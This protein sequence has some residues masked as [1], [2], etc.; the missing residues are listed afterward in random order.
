MRK[1]STLQLPVVF[2]DSKPT[3][4]TSHAQDT[5][6]HQLRI[7]DVTY[8]HYHR[9]IELGLCVSGNGICQVE[10]M[11]FPF[12]EGDVQIIFPYQRHLS[13]T[14][15]NSPSMWRWVNID[16]TEV[17]FQAGFT[18]QEHIQ[19]WLCKEMALC[20]II[21]RTRYGEICAT[22]KKVFEILC[23]KPDTFLHPQQL[24]ATQLMDLILQLCEASRMLPK[25]TLHTGNFAAELI[26][27]LNRINEDI[28]AG[29]MPKVT[30]LPALCGMSPANFRRVFKKTLGLSPKIY[31]TQCCIHKAKK[32]LTYTNL[33]VSQIAS[34][35]GYENISG[36]NRCFQEQTGTTPTN[37]RHMMQL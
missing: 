4:L 12:S 29:D 7:Y 13:K 1:Q 35:I 22:V 10:D 20:G 17:F 27:A 18:T 36:F 15:D 21:D 28:R 2:A 9:Y 23:A 3:I 19:Q 14:T 25:L 5:I 8:L 33:P 31:I 37:F 11:S 24:F 16:L 30:E 34:D 6:V 32:L 26:P